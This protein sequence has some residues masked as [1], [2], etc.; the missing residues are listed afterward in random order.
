MFGVTN[1]HIEWSDTP[2]QYAYADP[3][4]YYCI[5]NGVSYGYGVQIIPGKDVTVVAEDMKKLKSYNYTKR[6]YCAYRPLVDADK[7][8]K[9]LQNYNNTESAYK[10]QSGN[11]VIK[12]D[13]VV[14]PTIDKEADYDWYLFNLDS[15][16]VFNSFEYANWYLVDDSSTQISYKNNTFNTSVEPGAT[17]KYYISNDQVANDHGVFARGA[18]KLCVETAER[19]NMP[20]FRIAYNT[21][22]SE[23][24]YYSFYANGLAS[25][26]HNAKLAVQVIKG[27]DLP[28]ITDLMKYCL[29]L[30]GGDQEV[31]NRY[32]NERVQ[33]P[34]FYW[35]VEDNKNVFYSSLPIDKLDT[36]VMIP[37]DMNGYADLKVYN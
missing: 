25:E 33:K 37:L 8:D 27:A 23:P 14:I 2:I 28:K 12:I 6:E 19:F 24:I 21:S 22:S 32:Y 13:D 16:N 4:L 35:T 30:S 5:R 26:A 9:V 34:I 15:E 1:F 29:E 11:V 17:T 10:T 3:G 7:L 20:G 18:F 36:F 31:A